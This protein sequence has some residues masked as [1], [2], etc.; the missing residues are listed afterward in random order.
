[1]CTKKGERLDGLREGITRKDKKGESDGDVE[2]G[3]RVITTNTVRDSEDN[4]ACSTEKEGEARRGGAI[5][6]EK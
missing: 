6:M 4:D 1:M 5:A 2:K 3:D